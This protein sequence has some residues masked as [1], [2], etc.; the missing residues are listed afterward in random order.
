MVLGQYPMQNL[1]LAVIV[2]MPLLAGIICSLRFYAKRRSAGGI[3]IEDWLIVVA[4]LF[5]IIIIYPSW[6]LSIMWH[7]GVHIWDVN[8][9]YSEPSMDEYYRMTMVFYMFSVW[10]LPLVK[11]SII[12]LLLKVGGI[13]APVRKAVYVL[14]AINTIGAIIPALFYLF[15]CPPL[16]GNNWKPTTFGN[17]HCAGRLV[18]G[19]INIFQ[20][21]INM[22][23]DLLTFPIPVYLTWKLQKASLRDRLIIVFLFS[24]SLGVTAIGAV[25]IYLTYKERL[26]RKPEVDWT[27]TIAFCVNH[28]EHGMAIIFAC[29]PSLRVL[30]LGWLGYHDGET[31]R[32][33]ARTR[34]YAQPYGEGTRRGSLGA[35]SS[36]KK[37]HT[38]AIEVTCLTT[39]DVE[40]T[41]IKDYPYHLEHATYNNNGPENETSSYSGSKTEIEI[42]SQKY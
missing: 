4:V 17:L 16:T 39:F 32:S 23:T 7:Y 22:F 25:R 11:A 26:Y 20:V 15:E 30:I 3:G 14:F 34:S 33:Y 38:R 5:S 28:L 13:I 37:V 1:C 29:I 21:C 31:V 10:I 24:L 18:I 27:W 12:I 6:R 42:E 8:W 41:A 35:P 2:M 36:P 19:R 9:H 40:S